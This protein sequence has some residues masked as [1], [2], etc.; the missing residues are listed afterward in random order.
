[1]KTL[2]FKKYIV[3]GY[4]RDKLLD[5]EP[6]DQDYLIVTKEGFSTSDTINY[7][8][9]NG[10]KQVGKDFPVFLDPETNDEWALARI[11]RKSG[12]GYSGFQTEVDNV[13]IYDDLKRRDLTINS[14]AIDEETGEY[15]EAPNSTPLEDIK[16]KIL[17]PTSEAF[18]EDPLRFLRVARMS[19]KL[20]DFEVDFESF[21]N[22]LSKYNMKEE[23]KTI[24][25]ERVFKELEKSLTTKK[26]SNFFR[27]LNKLNILEDFFPFISHSKKHLFFEEKNGFE[28]SM[29]ILDEVS[30]KTKENKTKFS[31]I[32]LY[33]LLLFKS[34]DLESVFNK[35]SEIDKIPKKYINLLKFVYLHFEDFKN[36]NNLSDIKIVELLTIDRL[37]QSEFFEEAMIILSSFDKNIDKNY[38]YISNLYYFLKKNKKTFTPTKDIINSFSV[39]GKLNI[40]LKNQWILLKKMEV[41]NSFYS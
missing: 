8:T 9:S 18:I 6:N 30:K 39:E 20:P 35:L 33:S 37:S 11:E 36:F 27:T 23:F 5:L 28:I 4:V 41:F 17:R 31:S 2:P 3:G 13:S 26:P 12:I 1:L 19:A 10:F 29:D 32:Y 15:I 40:D 21:N 14:I 22:L 24:S 16:N 38:Q 25:K 34:K 7:L